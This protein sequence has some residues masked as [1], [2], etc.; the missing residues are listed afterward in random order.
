MT[1][2]PSVPLPKPA[3]TL[4]FLVRPIPFM[5]HWRRKLGETFHASLY[6]PGEVV[7]VSSPESVKAIFSRDRVN[8]I[9]GGRNI[10]LGP[11]LGPGSLLLQ[12]GQEH[13]R[14]RKL[15]LPPFHG[16]RMR[17]YEEAI[18]EVTR[19]AIAGWREGE[20][21]PLHPTMQEITLE[22]ILRAVF[23]VSDGKRHDELSDGLTEILA[24]TAT[25]KAVGLLFPGLRDSPPYRRLRR[26][27]DRVDD[28]LA[29]EISERRSDPAIGE[30]DDILSMLVQARFDDGSEMSDAEVRDQ[31]MTLLLA[32]HETTATGLAWA[33]DLLFR[34]PEQ[35][36][37]LTEE[38]RSGD[39]HAYLDAVI[40]ETL[41][42]R[43][44]VPFTGRELREPTTL[45]G[46]DYGPGQVILVAIWLTHT[47]PDLYPDPFEFR[48]ERF[49]EASTETYSWV[50]FGGGTRR[51][52][53]AAFAELEM[54]V[55]L[56]TILRECDLEPGSNAPERPIRRNVTMS[57]AGGTPA[58]IRRRAADLV[59][60]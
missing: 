57:P 15:M 60:S 18:E 14:R 25:P 38:V 31:L 50:P 27:I 7:F 21:F 46:F 49:L 19:S 35:L 48:P 32:G 13:M 9:A 22:V 58:V 37:R 20:T 54:R 10:I 59:P 4:R 53:G 26:L 3:Q 28:L 40:D 29:S 17:A 34:H 44:V 52:I 23:G 1:A 56:R 2:P 5:E 16:E 24:A 33:F 45:D 11:L 36:V 43:P 12:E 30:R 41:R 8:T 39:D 55:A 51:C 47:R 42:V 6:G